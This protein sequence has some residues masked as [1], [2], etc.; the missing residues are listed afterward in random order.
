MSKFFSLNRLLFLGLTIAG[1]AA[2]ALG[3]REDWFSVPIAPPEGASSFTDITVSKPGC[4]VFFKAALAIGVITTAASWLWKRQWSAAGSSIACLMILIPLAYPYFVIVRSPHVSAD[5]A[6]L[7]MQHNNLT[8]LGGD[9]YLNAEYGSKGWRSKSYI[10]DAPRQLSVVSL[11]SWSP[12]ELGLHRTE[13]LMLWLGYSNAFCQFA[14]RGWALAI[15]GSF[16]LFLAS[17]QKEKELDFGRAG[18]AIALFTV[19]AIV[20]SVVGWSRPFMASQQIR[21][22]SELS[23]QKQ[24]EQA[25]FHLERAVEVL[26]VLGQDTFYVSQRGILDRRLGI[27]SDYVRL[28]SA[29]SFESDGRFDQA[30]TILSELCDS[31]NPA[32]RR[33]ANRG[34]LRFAIQDFNC[35]RFELS[36]ARFRFV[37]KRNPC[38]VKLI[39]LLQLQGIRESRIDRVEEMRDWMYAA[40]NRFNFGTKKILRAVAQQN[41][42]TA[43]GL[44]NDADEIWAAQTRAKKP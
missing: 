28:Q 26:P 43:T 41:S 30:F 32:I 11:P 15:V 27:E 13:D 40:S 22:A 8:W 35:A 44:T 12:W 5:A 39:Y 9:I 34:I 23:S 37:L 14:G 7:Q 31:E 17:L 29:R 25:S 3:V 2:V 6:W 42:A 33:E 18:S 24:Y 16:L 36:A 38:D 21:L 4:T 20:A 1:M 10:V 19:V